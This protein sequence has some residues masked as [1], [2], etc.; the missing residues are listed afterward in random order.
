[1]HHRYQVATIAIILPATLLTNLGCQ[2]NHR[3]AACDE[4]EAAARMLTGPDAHKAIVTLRTHARSQDVFVRTRAVSTAGKFGPELNGVTRAQCMEIVG[5]ALRD[6][7]GYVLHRA[8]YDIGQFGLEAR[9]YIETLLDISIGPHSTNAVFALESLGRIGVGQPEV[10]NRLI[11]AIAEQYPVAECEEY[12]Y[13]FTS[14]RALQSWGDKALPWLPQLRA[15]R[16]SFDAQRAEHQQAPTEQR[17]GPTLWAI[18]SRRTDERLL[19][20]VIE[21]LEG[22][23]DKSLAAPSETAD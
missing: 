5:A 12:P 23:D 4:I 2:R 10:G 6:P 3:F 9:P 13:R 8:T 1:M 21:A 15:I 7:S 14:L 18:R 22:T 11:Y 20:Q 17:D 19:T 16:D